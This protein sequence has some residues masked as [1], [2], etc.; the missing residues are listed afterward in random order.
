MVELSYN[1]RIT[2]AATWV[3]YQ[4][5]VTLT[6]ASRR[7]VK[8]L[9]K[10]NDLLPRYHHDTNASTPVGSQCGMTRDVYEDPGLN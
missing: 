1:S 7:D 5:K 8:S 10:S 9:S 3:R 2:V 6:K 4:A